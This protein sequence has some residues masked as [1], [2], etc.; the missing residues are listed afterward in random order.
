MQLIVMNPVALP[1]I[2]IPEIDGYKSGD[3]KIHNGT[4]NNI[5][6]GWILCNGQNGT[7]PMVDCAIVGAGGQYVPNQSF[8]ADNA[9]T[10]DHTLSA[11]QMPSHSH[12]RNADYVSSVD[13]DFNRSGLY[14]GVYKARNSNVGTTGGSKP[15]NHG[16]LDVRQKSIAVIWIMKL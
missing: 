10:Q 11:E 3:I 1:A 8:G 4:L 5:P 13:I 16:A 9:I 14:Y 2:E 6:D 12:A 15:H 7:P